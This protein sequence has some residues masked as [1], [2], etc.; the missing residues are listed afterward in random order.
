VAWAGFD[1][2]LLLALAATGFTAPRRSPYLATAAT[3]TAVPLAGAGTGGS[4]LHWP[5]T[6]WA[7]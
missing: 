5:D 6:E 4:A 1:V 3:A 7:G 2:I